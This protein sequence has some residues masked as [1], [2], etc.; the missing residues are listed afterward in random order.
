MV[1]H[2]TRCEDFKNGEESDT[3]IPADGNAPSHVF[4]YLGYRRSYFEKRLSLKVVMVETTS[5]PLYAQ[6]ASDEAVAAV[7]E[8]AKSTSKEQRSILKHEEW[9]ELASQFLARTR[10]L[11]RSDPPRVSEPLYQTCVFGGPIGGDGRARLRNQV[12]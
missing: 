12:N 8:R 5:E 3:T 9:I 7:T 11:V 1:Y 4:K 6:A 2:G 10:K